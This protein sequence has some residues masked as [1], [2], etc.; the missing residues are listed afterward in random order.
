MS[1]RSQF[2]AVLLCIEEVRREVRSGGEVL[3]AL[4]ILERTAKDVSLDVL[5]VTDGWWEQVSGRLWQAGR[6]AGQ[7]QLVP[8]PDG[9]TLPVTI[10]IR[11]R[12]V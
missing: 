7:L 9:E 8:R 1:L 5:A 10:T 11:E 6:D 4:E 12:K 2:E 3:K